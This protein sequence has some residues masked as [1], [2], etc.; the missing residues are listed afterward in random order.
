[1]EVSAVVPSGYLNKN[2]VVR[3]EYS[4]TQERRAL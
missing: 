2:T 1:M 3:L 4:P